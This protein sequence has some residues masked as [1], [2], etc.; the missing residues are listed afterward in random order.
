MVFATSQSKRWHLAVYG[1]V[2]ESAAAWLG[3]PL[4]L[5][6]AKQ[7]L[8]SDGDTVLRACEAPNPEAPLHRVKGKQKA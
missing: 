4:G 8:N 2:S 7:A 5:T 3:R 6:G 1:L